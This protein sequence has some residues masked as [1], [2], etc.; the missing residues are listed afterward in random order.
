MNESTILLVATEKCIVRL[1][2]LYFW[3]NQFHLQ[4][5]DFCIQHPALLKE[6]YYFINTIINSQPT[7]EWLKLPN[8]VYQCKWHTNL[9]ND[10]LLRIFWKIPPPWYAR[11]KPPLEFAVFVPDK[12]EVPELNFKSLHGYKIIF[13]GNS[14]HRCD[15]TLIRVAIV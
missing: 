4:Y 7:T 1:P 8:H 10:L 9:I 15:K 14:T 3:F 5:F 13:T 2:I 12:L 6:T 11:N